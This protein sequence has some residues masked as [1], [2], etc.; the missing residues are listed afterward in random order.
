MTMNFT[1]LD[2]LYWEK[3]KITKG[4]V[5]EYYAKMAPYMLPYLK[6]RPL[7][8]KRYPN[9]ISGE[10]FY[11]KDAGKGAPDFVKTATVQHGSKKVCYIV[12]QNVKSLLYVANLGSI[13]LHI[14]N[15]PVKN[16]SYPTYLVLDLDPEA[17]GFNA[18]IET[19]LV[20]HDILEKIGLPNY[21]KT[22]GATG[23]HIYI[24]LGSK[25]DYKTARHFAEV[26]ADI[27]HR[28]IPK[29][30]SLERMPK[31]RQKKVYIDCLQNEFGQI[32]VC[33]YSLRAR[34]RAPVSTPVSWEELKKGIDPLEFNMQTIFKRLARK[35]DL[36]KPVLGKGADLEKAFRK[37]TLIRA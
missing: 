25:Y 24:P 19:A 26:L 30:T 32:M 17:I 35:K 27:A 2:K 28:E 5:I 23:L 37:L 3:E 13:E 6:N 29:I 8:L 15:S 14:L 20:L 22:S 9:G 12:V 18:V 4:D 16:L 10:S 1:N 21:C 31:K 11:Q 34:Q 33:P 36:F 7:V